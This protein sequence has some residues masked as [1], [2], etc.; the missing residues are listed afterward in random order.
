MQEKAQLDID[1]VN[2]DHFQKEHTIIN[3]YTFF[4]KFSLFFSRNLVVRQN[5]FAYSLFAPNYWDKGI[6]KERKTWEEG[7]K[8]KFEGGKEEREERRDKHEKFL[9]PHLQSIKTCEGKT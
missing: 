8:E 4:E 3:Q 7:K 5:I 6:K 1:I 9:K 2:H